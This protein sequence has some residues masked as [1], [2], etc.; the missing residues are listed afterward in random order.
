MTSPS[1]AKYPT[2]E[3]SRAGGAG[4]FWRKSDR[5]NKSVFEITATP[6]G[7][8]SY[9]PAAQASSESTHSVKPKAH[10]CNAMVAPV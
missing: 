4:L 2:K 10:Y 8:Y 9:V 7:L 3:G 5:R 6:N 1:D